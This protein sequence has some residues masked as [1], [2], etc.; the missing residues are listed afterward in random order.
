[1]SFKSRGK[2]RLGTLAIML[3][4]LIGVVVPAGGALAGLPTG[5]NSSPKQN[6]AQSYSGQGNMALPVS[7]TG[8]GKTELPGDPTSLHASSLSDR[9]AAPGVCDTAG[10][11]EVESSTGT[12]AGVP[13]AYA[14][15]NLAF[16]AI[17]GGTLH[18]GVI[19][20]DVCGDTAETASAILNASGTGPSYTSITISPVGG[21]RTITGSIVGAIIKLNGADNVTIDG[22]IAGTGRNL[23]VINSNTSTATAAIWLASVAAGNGAS[24]NVIRNLELA[25]GANP[26]T[27]TVSTFG[28]IMS[29]TTISTT[30]NGVDNDNNSFIANRIIRSRYGIVTRGTTTDLNIAPIITDNIIGPAAFGADTIGKTGILLQADTGATVSRNTIQFVGCVIAQSCVSGAD[31]VGIGI[32][33]E[34]WGTTDTT[35]ITSNTYS[36]TKNV[37]HDIVEEQ[38][39]SVVAIK[40]ATTGS[41]VATNNVVA[42][43]FIYN[44]RGNGTSGDQLVGIGIAGGNT[45]KIVFN[46]ISI[47]GDMDP[48]TAASSTTYGNAIRIPGL[49]GTNN[50]NFTVMDNSIYLDVNSNTAANHYYAITLN[51]AAYLF[52]TGGLNYNN[53]YINAGN[54]QLRTGGLGTGTGNTP[55]TEFAALANWKLALTTPQDANSIQADPQYLSATD[56]HIQTTSPNESAGVT[57]AGV[58]DDIDAQARPGVPDIGADEVTPVGPGVLQFSSATYSASETA[59]TA[60]INVTRAGGVNGAVTVDYATVAGGTATGGASCTAGVDYVPTSGTLMWADLDGTAKSFTVTLC[61]DGVFEGNETV[62]LALSNPTG[63]ATL[64][65]PSSA[66]LTIVD[67]GNT[68]SGAYSVGTGQTATSLTNPGGMFEAL[69]NG[70]VAGNI[71]LNIT[72]DL[73]GETGT[74]ALNQYAAGFSVTIKPSGAPRT[75]TGSSASYMIPFFGADMVTIDGSLVGGTDRSLTVT[76]T[77]G[78]GGI[79]FMTGTNGAQNNTVKNVNIWGGS[80]TA[81]IIGLAFGGNTFGTAGADNDNNRVENCDLRSSIYGIYSVGVSALNKNTGVVITRN[82]MTATGASRIGRVGIFVGF[83]DGIQITENN[84][85]GISSAESADAIGIGAGTQALG[86]TLS[87]PIDLT[88]AFISRNT[89]GVVQQTNTFSAAGI[90][91]ESGTSGTN[92]VVNNMISGVIANS[93][94]GDIVAGIYAVPIAGSTQNIYHNSVS[95]TGDRGATATQYGSFGL[96]IGG[97][98]QPINVINNI[99]MNTQT[100]SGGGAGGRSYAIGVGYTTFANLTSNYNDLYVNGAQATLGLTGAL[101]NTAGGGTGTDRVDLAAWQAGTGKDANSISADPL[102]VSTTDLHITPP[103]PANNTGTPIGTVTT[104]FDGQTRSATAPEIGADEIVLETPTPTATETATATA[105][106]TETATSTSTSTATDTS[107]ATTTSTSTNTAVPPTA[108]STAVTSG[109]IINELDADQVGT[110]AMEFVEL[111]DGGVGNTS[112]TGKVVVFYNGAVDTSYAAFDL[113]TFSTNGAGYFTLGNAGVPGVDLVFAG[114]FLQ[115]GQDAVALYNGDATS[116]PNGTAV[117][118]ANLIDAIV[119]DTAD[120]D[121]PGLLVLLN[122]GQPQVDENG[123]GN[124][125]GHSNQRCP[126]GSGGARNTNTYLQAAPNPDG[127]N[128][129]GAGATATPTVFFSPTS[130][131]TPGGATAT[132]TQTPIRIRQ[133]Q[134]S[135]HRS[136]FEGQAVANVPGIVTALAPNGFYMQDPTSDADDATSEG[137]F[138]FTS[139]SPT[140]TVAVGDMVAVS[141]TVTEFRAGG[142]SSTNLTITEI[143]SPVIAVQSTGNTLPTPVVLGTGGRIPPNTIIEDD[144]TGDVETSGV[145][146]VTQDGID[147]YESLEAMRVQVNNPVAVGPRNSFGEIPVLGDD[148]ANGG[149]RTTRGGVIIQPNDFNPERIILNDVILTTPAVNVGDHFSGPAVGVMNYDFGNF[150]LEIT[151]AL[152]GVSSGLTR[153]VAATPG[154]N[155]IVIGNFNVENLDPNDPPSQFSNLAGL[156]VNNMKSPDIISIEEIQDNDGTVGG[157][158]STVVDASTTW[159]MLISAIQSAGGPTYQFRNVNPVDD[160]DGGEP[161]GNIRQGFLFRTDR[162]VA[163]I[164]RPGGCSTCANS[165]VSGPGGPELAFSPGRV[166][167]TNTAFNASRKPLAGEFTYNGHKLFIIGNHLNSKGGDHPLF[168]RFQPPVRSSEVQRNQQAQIINNFVDSILAV[169]A[170]ANVVVLGDMNDFYF[171]AT[172]NIIEGDTPSGSPSSPLGGGVLQNLM[173]TLALPERYSYVF[174]GNSQDLDNT[175]VSSN[176]LAALAEFDPLHVNSE[177]AN[178]DSDHD[179]QVSRYTLVGATPTPTGTSLPATSTNTA[180]PSTATNTA[181]AASATSTNT[182][183]APSATT[184]RTSTAT[185]TAVP[186]TGTNTAVVPSATTTRTSTA[187]NTVIAASA[188]ATVCTSSGPVTFTGSIDGSEPTHNSVL[189]A[190]SSCGSTTPCPGQLTGTFHYDTYTLVNNTGAPVCVTVTLSDSACVY[191]EVYSAVPTPGNSCTSYVADSNLGS[192]YQLTI[193]AN[194]T[195]YLVVEEFTENAGCPS[196][197]ATVTGLPGGACVTATPTGTAVAASATATRTNTAVAASATS[198]NTTVA[199]SATTTRTNTPV[200]A[201]ATSTNTVAVPSVTSTAIAPTATTIISTN[202]VVPATAT[203]TIVPPSI[204]PVPPTV[205]TIPSSTAVPTS[206]T[207][208]TSVPPTSTATTPPT[209]T[210]VP[211]STP[212]AC[213]MPFT[214]V[215]QYNPF[216]VYIKCLYCRGVISGYG[217]GTFR[218]YAEITR[219]QMSKVVSNSAGFNEPVSG[220]VYTDVPPAH[221]FYMWIMRLSNRGIAT[222]YNTAGQCPTGVPCFRPENSLTRGQMAK[223]DSNAAGFSD[224]PPAGTLTFADVPPSNPFYIWIE[225]LSR[226]GIINGYD[227]GVNPMEPCDGQNRPYYRPYTDITRGQAAKI[228]SNTFFPVDCTPGIPPILPGR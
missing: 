113:D 85:S 200:V 177:F 62:N 137:I 83:D 58:A 139:T 213:V 6:Q 127:F 50:A 184:T 49:N 160:Q 143:G 167:P 7:Q 124:G 94:L 148:G 77:G 119:Y 194:T 193:P 60:T 88:N 65:T 221:P 170:N 153:E 147:F 189:G 34:T 9:P 133:I 110:D 42:N 31:R 17:N 117:T 95:M 21:A 158:G 174:D 46:S 227:C 79:G 2:Q 159:N 91:L 197:T 22:R 183:V 15:L 126:N 11:I 81:T 8:Q 176:L 214:D 108:T 217:D 171:S 123:G 74:V 204:T 66:V 212:T 25:C 187:T 90:A 192:S 41:G 161:G 142:A 23:S 134:A 29:G 144:A 154:P 97:T 3:V 207:A 63:G 26:N 130:T 198:T 165:V 175:L 162:G 55:G 28:I 116:F 140:G 32:G 128:T 45:D 61:T 223:I 155:Q 149:V 135:Q 107:T 96:A 195:Y 146:D 220:Q 186:A 89:I 185:N 82:V 157:T 53:Y 156:I 68:F 39:F 33:S 16:T 64:G 205:T 98:D 131:N 109:L 138:V 12:L 166:D 67:A 111:Y 114:D 69:N 100:Q 222:G 125:T 190:T 225:R 87:T 27:T 51:S 59:G 206:T 181:V 104:D 99:L 48:G 164:D 106:A 71:T 136:P 179:P 54:A 80:A 78:G 150:K 24:N 129:C 172:I 216:Y 40:L 5:N 56:L 122:A 36:V 101:L 10:P 18:T 4:L 218:P 121:D 1:M 226:R 75:I 19:T 84:I 47:T 203:N 86:T 151:Q 92:T 152:S 169:N 73:A 14:S 163:F 145:F 76:N 102:F 168:G 103:S 199:A 37:I 191:S 196:Y 118:T 208:A 188:T 93:N 44:I 209:A 52:G 105:T 43:N 215:D 38:T 201:S 132:A 211:S 112:L 120:P 224:T 20:I 210:T 173:E 57:V 219:G 178:Q 13:T 35:T 202:T 72:S 228:V 115:N 180:V 70:T 30:S 182:A 141:G